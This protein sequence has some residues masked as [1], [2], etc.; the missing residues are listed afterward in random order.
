MF[1]RGVPQA[2]VARQLGVSRES[3]HRWYH[4]W[5]EGGLRALQA[6]KRP[7]RP[8]LLSPADLRRVEKVL[9]KGPLAAGYPTDLWTLARVAEVIRRETGVR[10]HPG[11]V[12]KLLRAMGWRLKRPVRVP[13][14]RDEEAIERFRRE[15]WPKVKRGLQ[16][17]VPGSSSKTNRG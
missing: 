2:E 6:A 5:R 9:L 10:Y 12:W 13:R 4:A 15:R 11:H 16:G 1:R 14:E 17:A 7:G 3:A 8:P